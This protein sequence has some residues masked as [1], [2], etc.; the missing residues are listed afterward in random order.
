MEVKKAKGERQWLLRTA[1]CFI[2]IELASK[3]LSVLPQQSNHAL[4]TLSLYTPTNPSTFEAYENLRSQ[5]RKCPRFPRG[6]FRSKSH[7]FSIQNGQNSCSI[8]RCLSFI[9]FLFYHCPII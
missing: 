9:S 1:L 6:T 7:C 4:L 3:T 5:R 2:S 8:I